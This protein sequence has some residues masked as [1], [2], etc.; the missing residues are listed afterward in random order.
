MPQVR[1][2]LA[3]DS[4]LARSAARAILAREPTF[5]V[6]GEAADGYEAVQ[7]VRELQPD[8]VMMDIRMPRC[9]GLLATKLIKRER[10]AVAVVILSVSDDAGDL[11]EAIRCGAQGYLLKNLSPDVWL[12]YLSGFAR[13][14]TAIP[15]HVAREILHEFARPEGRRSLENPL[16]PREQEVLRLVGEG[17]T[18]RRIAESLYLSEN[19]VKNHMKSILEKVQVQNRV[20]LALYAREGLPRPGEANQ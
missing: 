8:L 1:V 6:V 5:T 9:D 15:R 11:F 14:E 16:T 4:P 13:G 18:N 3:D 2:V 12:E 7:L 17:L 19:T 10:P 20:Q